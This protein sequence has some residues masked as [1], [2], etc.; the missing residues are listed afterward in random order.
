MAGR[1]LAA[2]FGQAWAAQTHAPLD[3]G[4][5]S[6]GWLAGWW[7]WRLSPPSIF[8][9]GSFRHAPWITPARLSC[10]GALVVWQ[11]GASDSPPPALALPGLK[12][13][14]VKTFVGRANPAH[15]PLAHRLG[16]RRAC[17]PL[18]PSG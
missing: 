2:T 6:D 17:G 16:R 14:G 18:C 9:D 13:M 12:T 5:A 11:T 1:A 8:I 3:I 15:R 7:R 10:E 4:F